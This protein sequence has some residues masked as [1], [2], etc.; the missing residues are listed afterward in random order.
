MKNIVF[1]LQMP[2]ALPGHGTE[3]EPADSAEAQ[4]SMKAD[5]NY[6]T[7]ANL[8]E[9]R[10]GR[11]V[12]YRSGKTKLLLGDS[13][14]DINLGIDPN[15]LQEAVSITTNQTERS[16]NA[17]DLGRINAKLSAVPDWESMLNNITDKKS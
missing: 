6:C 11:I 17:T 4:N 5:T 13:Q 9:G 8:E 1:F 12:R 16:G 10:I 7:M 14:F 3:Q 2:H 15:L